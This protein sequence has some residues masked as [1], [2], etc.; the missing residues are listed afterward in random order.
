MAHQA[1]Q[2]QIAASGTAF[3][4]DTGFA[5]TVYDSGTDLVN[6]EA[7]T[8]AGPLVAGTAYE[9][10]VRHQSDTD[11]WSQWAVPDTFT[12]LNAYVLECQPGALGLTGTDASLLYGRVLDAQPG[13][14]GLTG[15]DASL[16]YGRVLNADPGALGLTGTT[17]TLL[18]GRVLICEPGALTMTGTDANLIWSGAPTTLSGSV[19]LAPSLSGTVALAAR[20]N[21][22]VTLEPS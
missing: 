8:D 5:S 7:L 11:D 19:A 17:A 16:L 18:Y 4:A 13:A 21:G 14:L 10:T 2:W 9:A 12:T 1:S 15:T 3:D 22:T 20:L 6:L